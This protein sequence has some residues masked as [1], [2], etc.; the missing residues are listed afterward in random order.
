MI[1]KSVILIVRIGAAVLLL[2]AFVLTVAWLVLMFPATQRRIISFAEKQVDR[3]LAGDCTIGSL[4]TNFISHVEIKNIALHDAGGHGDSIVIDRVRA[5]FSPLSLLQ[6]KIDIRE[7]VID[8]LEAFLTVSPDGQLMIP[9]LPDP[10]FIASLGM[11]PVE[12]EVEEPSEWVVYIGKARAM[13][14]NATYSD[15]SL[16]FVGKVIDA[17]AAAEIYNYDSMHLHLAV[18]D[19]SYE[20]PWWN[21]TVD[22]IGSSA[23]LTLKGMVFD[24]IFF[25]GSSTSIRGSGRIPFSVSGYW[26]LSAE[27]E[28]DLAPIQAVYGNIPTLTSDGHVKG[29]ASWKGTL[30]QPV[31]DFRASGSGWKTTAFSIPTLFTEASYDGDS[32]ISMRGILVTDIGQLVCSSTVSMP[33][34]FSKPVVND[35]RITAYLDNV[36]LMKTGIP[37]SLQRYIPWRSGKG[38]IFAN[39][40]GVKYLPDTLDADVILYSKDSTVKDMTIGAALHG[41]RWTLN[42]SWDKSIVSGKGTV[43]R[44]GTLTGTYNCTIGNV[45]GI[46]SL[47]IKERIDGL[48]QVQ[49]TLQ[50]TLSDPRLST[51]IISDTLSWRSII[52]DSLFTRV[53]ISKASTILKPSFVSLKARVDSV[54]SWFGIDSLKG[55]IMLD[56]MV[57][58]PVTAPDIK[59]MLTGTDIAYSRWTADSIDALV[60]VYKLDSIVVRNASAIKESARLHGAGNVSI[61]SRHIDVKI[62]QQTHTGS[63]WRESGYIHINSVFR[64][65][66]VSTSV[67]GKSIDI[68]A[69][70]KWLPLNDSFAGLCDINA[71]LH[72]SF[73]N[74]EGFLEFS[75]RNPHYN[76]LRIQNIDGHIALKDSIVIAR[77]TAAITD[78]LSPVVLDVNVP[79]LYKDGVR[80]DES[81]SRPAT[82]ALKGHDLSAFRLIKVL[83]G[84]W[85][86]DGIVQCDIDLNLHKKEWM[87][88][89][90]LS[91][92]AGITMNGKENIRSDNSYFRGL[93]TGT[94]EQP[95]IQYLVTTGKVLVAEGTI[96]SSF[97]QGTLGTDTLR[98]DI[99][100]LSLPRNGQLE[101]KGTL[102]LD[103]TDSLLL[104]PGLEADF[105]VVK[106][107]LQLLSPFL[108][109]NLIRSG[110]VHGDGKIQID[111]GRPVLSGMVYIDSTRINLEDITP[112][113]GPLNAVIHMSNDSLILQKMSGVWG[114]GTLQAQGAVV[115]ST[116][117]IT[118]LSIHTRGS[119]LSVEMTDVLSVNVADLDVTTSKQADGFLIKGRADI[120][121]SRVIRDVRVTDFI[122]DPGDG[123]YSKV[124]QDSTL[125]NINMQIKLNFLESPV[126]DMNLGYFQLGGDVALAGTTRNPSYIG[127]I[128]I[129]QGYVIYLDRQFEIDEGSFVNYDPQRLNPVI[130]MKAHTEVF[131]TSTGSEN[132]ENYIIYIDVSGTLEDPVVKL[133]DENKKLNE[134]DIISILTLGQRLGSIGDD[135]G[136]RLKIFASQSIL[137]FGTRKLEQVLKMDRIDIQ[138]DIFTMNSKTSPTLTLSKRISPRLLVTYETAIRDLTR[139]KITALFRLTRRLFVKGNA[140]SD[141][142]GLDLIFKYSK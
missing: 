85:S 87:L 82:V 131:T 112:S 134:V 21:G 106:F 120:G 58:G 136:E 1:K 123:E 41:S 109:D 115:W 43:D 99:M 4:S 139:R 53:D 138:G 6:K 69:V 51:Q 22:T 27:I 103:K 9:A 47:V 101:L 90:E 102:P 140:D 17:H 44:S 32:S 133:S 57:S 56:A 127:S 96:D 61:G 68:A 46:S 63:S 107:P 16:Q 121:S 8:T 108:P 24:D 116:K 118:D 86:S 129:D 13:H 122:H 100:R 25:K 3:I 62:D 74:P 15:S 113:I 40:S 66:L 19:G 67:S 110:T 38:S 79:I 88:N 91:F 81:G 45:V 78:S 93:L 114:R 52:V 39:G 119:N 124:I 60:D 18:P 20:S 137:G 77:V 7:A 2:S 76:D 42:G 64:K 33:A 89:G 10:A 132:V 73:V 49:G 130:N 84:D 92:Q 97:V 70:N 55:S 11:N 72:G 59:A 128:I 71:E 12:N 98:C 23:I 14:V 28:S 26:D 125:N 142:Y 111:G 50:G 94:V 36:D 117:G 105:A 83:G 126:V 5:R 135:L 54:A 30:D 35:Y 141:D 75:I 80:L 29:V 104:Q 95:V 48:I 31:L 34:L 37:D 65:D